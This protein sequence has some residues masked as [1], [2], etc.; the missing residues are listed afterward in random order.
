MHV[1]ARDA[2]DI[3]SRQSPDIARQ[4]RHTASTH[5]ARIAR[6]YILARTSRLPFARIARSYGSSWSASL[7]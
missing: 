3:F 2:R 7:T 5:V 6:S 4:A 1:G